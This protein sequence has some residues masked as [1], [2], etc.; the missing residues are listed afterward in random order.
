MPRG[1]RKRSS[2]GMYHIMLRG[3]DERELFLSDV[4]HI[5]FIEYIRKAKEKS[6]C[7]L[8]GYCLMKNH[9]HVLL[10]EDNEKVGDIV[11]RIAVGYAQYYNYRYGRMGHLFQN[12]FTSEPIE[13]EKYFLTVLRHIHQNPVETGTVKSV[14]DYRWSSYREYVS[15]GKVEVIDRDFALE[16]LSG[17]SGFVNFMQVKNDNDDVC[18]E[19]N[20]KKRYTD[21]DLRDTISSN[22]DIEK[23][24]EVDK[25]E[26]NKMLREIKEMTQVSNRQ[27]SRVL[28]IGRGILEKANSK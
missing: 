10:K 12:R 14:S 2:I 3:I 22:I 24:G 7:Y 23:L 16:L 27:L 20:Y 9:A 4:D 5:E 19:Y 6:N 26:R 15:S 28:G 1:E 13:D 25:E 21:D 17:R 8:Y 18:L 11:R